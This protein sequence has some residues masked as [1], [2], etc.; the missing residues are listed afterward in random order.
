M[1]N[2]PQHHLV[3]CQTVQTTADL[4]YQD[5]KLWSRIL[6]AL[7]FCMQTNSDDKYSNLVG[8]VSQ[9]WQAFGGGNDKWCVY[10]QK[11]KNGGFGLVICYC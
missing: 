8:L 7:L 10:L 9:I 5:P 4:P 11:K 2:S 3:T 6:T 1:N